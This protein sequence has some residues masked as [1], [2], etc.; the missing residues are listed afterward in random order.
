MGTDWIY[1]K[2]KLPDQGQKIVIVW[3]DGTEDECF[4]DGINWNADIIPEKWKPCKG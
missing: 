4:W 2:D 3:N 1:F